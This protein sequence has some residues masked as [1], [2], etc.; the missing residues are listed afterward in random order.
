MDS[1]DP[2]S[3]GV[4]VE[5]GFVAGGIAVAKEAVHA[6]P[7]RPDLRQES[8]PGDPGYCWKR[9]DGLPPPPSGEADRIGVAV[10]A[11]RRISSTRPLVLRISAPPRSRCDS[12]GEF[13]DGSFW[14]PGGKGCY[15]EGFGFRSPFAG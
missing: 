6:T 12:V 3:G 1:I 4:V 11:P 2:G 14:M 13:P 8:S 10:Q 9:A 7:P 15:L 5:G